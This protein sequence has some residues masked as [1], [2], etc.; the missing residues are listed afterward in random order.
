MPGVPRR[1]D[2]APKRL[3]SAAAPAIPARP[4]TASPSTDRFRDTRRAPR[5]LSTATRRSRIAERIGRRVAAF[6]TN[7]MGP[8]AV[9]GR[10]EIRIDR[11]AA[12]RRAIDL[13]DPAAHAFRVKLRIPRAVQRVRYVDAPPVAAE[14]DHLRR[15][16]ERPALRMLP[17]RY[18]SAQ[19]YAASL[20]RLERVAHV[21]LLQVTGAETRDVQKFVVEAQVDVGNQRRHRLERLERGRQQAFIGG[22]GGDFDH[23]AN[24]PVAAVAIPQP[25]RGRQI[26]GRDDHTD[27]AESLGRVVRWPQLERHLILGADVER[28]QM[29]PVAQIPDMN[30]MPI[31]VAEQQFGHDAV[32]DHVRRAPFAGDGHVPSKMPPEILREPLRPAIDFPS[33]EHVEALVVEQ[34]YSAR[35]VAAWRAQR[36]DVNRVGTAMHSMRP[37]V[38]RA[39]RYLLSLDGLHQLGTSRVGPGVENVDAR[40]AQPGHQQ[41]APLYM[42]MRCVRTQRG[43]ACVPA[44]VMQLVAGIRDLSAPDHL[45]VSS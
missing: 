39:R 37:A 27:E 4:R 42:R 18:D 13:R 28:L 11:H 33:S 41:V 43:A 8:L 34:E 23:L 19:T 20:P 25:N 12:R 2:R 14:L 3:S 9:A 30:R 38:A 24:F 32:F 5:P 7:L 17:V 16:V 22:L 31:L 21:V 1:L 15:A 29:P 40:R 36:A 45:R 35:P 44:K 6:E 10:E 26:L